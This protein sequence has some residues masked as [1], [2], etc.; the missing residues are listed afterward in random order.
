MKAGS[1]PVALVLAVLVISGTASADASSSESA[2]IHR[3]VM[4]PERLV[5]LVHQALAQRVGAAP[6]G[7][8]EIEVRPPAVELAACEEPRV[9]IP[10]GE[11]SGRVHVRV[12]CAG[13][14]AWNMYLSADVAVM[15]RVPIA[16]QP[17]ARGTKITAAMLGERAVPRHLVR[18]HT[19]IEAGDI[20]G[21]LALRSLRADQPILVHALKSP[22][23]ISKGDRVAIVSSSGRVK[24]RSFGTALGGGQVGDQIEVRN[25]SSQ[26][27]IRP[28]IAGPGRVST[29]PPLG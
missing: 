24:I 20:V 26:R 27:T 16:A 3:A 23:A 17:I 12:G 4:P 28:W 29:S 2:E 19:L 7:D 9:T 8:I 11:L 14:D 25:E 18:T 6:G 10:D 15:I 21:K 5:A 13:P 1:A 22:Q